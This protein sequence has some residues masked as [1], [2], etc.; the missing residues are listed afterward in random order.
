MPKNDSKPILFGVVQNWV[1]TSYNK[2]YPQLDDLDQLYTDLQKESIDDYSDRTGIPYNSINYRVKKYFTPEM[3]VNII[4][5][6]RRHQNNTKL[7]KI[8]TDKEV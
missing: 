6:R 7:S 5:K 2:K 1:K 8:N 3:E 4:Q